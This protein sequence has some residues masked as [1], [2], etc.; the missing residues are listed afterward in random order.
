MAFGSERA[1]MKPVEGR[2]RVV[3]GAVAPQVDC[4]RYP[5]K[6]V[7]G[8]G[9]AVTVAI[10]GDGHD[11]ISARLLHKKSGEKAWQ[12]TP[13]LP[14][15]NDLWRGT[16]AVESM[17]THKYCVEGWVDD[18]ATWR[19]DFKKRADAG[20]DLGLA[21]R[22]GALLLEQAAARAKKTDGTKLRSAA[23][24]LRQRVG[25]KHGEDAAASFCLSPEVIELVE[26]YP[27]LRFAT[28]SGK[29][30]ELQVDRERA[31]F[32]AWYE[33]FPR[34]AAPV[35]GRHG[36]FADCEALLPSIA[37][38]GFDVLYLPPIHPIGE[39]YRKGRNNAPEAA[40]GEVGS[41][42]AIGSELGGHKSIHPQLGTLE[43]FQRLLGN[44]KEKGMEIALDIAFQCSPDHP[45]V[46]EH[47]EWFR[48]RPDG[49]I[50]Y[51]ENPPKKYQDIYPFDFETREWRE[52]WDELKS[53]FV[54]WADQ[55]VRIF[56]VDN[57]HTK[58]FAFWEWAIGAVKKTYPDAIFLAEAFT[59]PHAMYE[60]AKLGFS[61]SYTYFTWKTTK[62]ELTEYFKELSQTEVKEFFRPNVWPN[63]PDILH[64]S[65]QKGG[66]GEFILRVA[67]AATLGANYG[68][69]GPA[70][71]LCE[72]VAVREGSEEYLDSEKYE[73][74]RWDRRAE[75]SIAPVIA[76]LNEIRKSE[77]AL[78]NIESLRFHAVDNEWM[79]C[80]SKSSADG[81][82]VVLVA[83]N[84][85][86]ARK[87]S[88]WT[89]LDLNAIGI[90]AGEEFKVIDLLDG[91][92]YL[93]KGERNYVELWPETRA[94]HVFRV[95]TAGARKTRPE[96]SPGDPKEVGSGNE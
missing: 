19:G 13:M 91:A 8:D 89:K 82:N 66:R 36:T 40:P 35:E 32:S 92:E 65:L 2:R 4:G 29:E 53:V 55:G 96:P 61:Q 69:Y 68:I 9:F 50:Q 49:S 76:R 26:K 86:P 7:V 12:T 67:L 73:L 74:R 87:Q 56:R 46:R 34:S 62:E 45:Y 48:H 52:L 75:S 59:R 72:G 33:M 71:E 81:A 6:R 28:R 78:R 57:P 77:A 25:A 10:F 31:A 20:E 79:I 17:G 80:Y 95:E 27:D 1:S 47:P 38:M 42:W 23:N 18:F 3:I 60:L 58:A 39:S 51:A 37:A 24:E 94:A 64:E 5:V 83:V 11:A 44:A 43:D 54:F 63:T 22:S 41:P 93:W 15:G 90:Q 16:F 84:L 70:Y 14:I 21:L 30:L 85:D 88:G